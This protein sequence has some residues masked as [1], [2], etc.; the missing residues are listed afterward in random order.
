MLSASGADTEKDP[1]LLLS[2]GLNVVLNLSDNALVRFSV[3]TKLRSLG[4]TTV[5]TFE[6]ASRTV[7]DGGLGGF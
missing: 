5:E 3:I 7:E 4:Y 6:Y 1:V 2:A